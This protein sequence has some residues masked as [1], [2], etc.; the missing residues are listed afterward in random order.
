MLK[1]IDVNG[2]QIACHD[3]SAK[4]GKMLMGKVKIGNTWVIIGQ[5][6]MAQG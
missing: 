1:E 2:A 4:S 5:P 3:G 6:E